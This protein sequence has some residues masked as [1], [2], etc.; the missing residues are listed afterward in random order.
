MEQPGYAEDRCHFYGKPGFENCL[1]I[2]AGFGRR[3]NGSA[4]SSQYFNACQNCVR[5]PYPV[6][7][8]FVE[9]VGQK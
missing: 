4:P 6:P 9:K 3:E 7:A 8:Q 5:K 2:E 1:K